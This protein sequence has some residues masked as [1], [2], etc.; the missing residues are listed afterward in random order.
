MLAFAMPGGL[1]LVIVGIVAVLLFGKR[2]PQVA[3]SIGNSFNQFKAGMTDTVGE[4]ND[5]KNTIKN[6]VQDVQR[7]V[8]H[9]RQELDATLR[10]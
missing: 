5:C 8:S 6:E 9:E 10:G 3:Y 1:E 4:I 7:V 2:L